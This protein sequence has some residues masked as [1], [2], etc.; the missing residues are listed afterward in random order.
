M[1]RRID[2]L[3]VAACFLVVLLH[4]SGEN[5]QAFGPKW[6]SANV[7]ES[8]TRASVPIFFMIS[9][10]TLLRKSETLSDYFLKRFIRVIPPL[11]AWSVFYLWWLQHNGVQTGNW[12][13]AI[14]Q[15]PTMFHLWFFYALI[16][17]YLFV[18][19]MRT[20]H[21][22][23]TKTEVLW[24]LTIW[25]ILGCIYPVMHTV[26]TGSK[27]EL[28][29]PTTVTDVYSLSYFGQYA[30]YFI[31]GA[32]LYEINWSAKKGVA[33]FLVATGFTAISTL[34]S[35]NFV[36]A[37]TPI[38]YLY[39]SPSVAAAAA[40]LFIAFMALKP[41]Q[42]SPV[43]RAISNCTLGIYGLHPF[44]VDPWAKNF[45]LMG[46]T[47]VPWIDPLLASVLVFSIC[48]FLVFVTRN[49]PLFGWRPLRY[50]I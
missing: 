3:R 14:L 46:I 11:I 29:H 41:G 43:L 20:L 22:G 36:G 49:L 1:D 38:F 44:A 21:K 50:A 33:I 35:S 28:A 31:L 16:G 27:N 2:A 30:G 47:G 42:S 8:F 12:A 5:F 34:L 37:P 39:W 25:F 13:V 32:F 26:L 6:F 15:G 40:G 18:P 24:L 48:L 7:I 10:A 45:G 19:A 17:L 4:I 9:G 23:A